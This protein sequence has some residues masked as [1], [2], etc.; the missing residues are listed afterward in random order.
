[1]GGCF[2][3]VVVSVVIRCDNCGNT[4]EIEGTPPERVVCPKCGSVVFDRFGQTRDMAASAVAFKEKVPKRLGEYEIISEIRRGAMG[5]VYR[6]YQRR[7][8]RVVA[9]K[10]LIAGQHA[11]EEQVERFRREASSIARLSHPA[12]VPLYD[13]G[14]AEGFHYIAMEYV[15]GESLDVLLRRRGR[16]EVQDAL[17]IIRQVASAL[18]HAHSRGIVHRDIKPANILLDR[19]G[20]VRVTDFGLAK[21]L[22]AAAS[23]TQSGV[24][25]GTPHYMSPEQARGRSKDVDIR[26]DVYSVGA[27]LYEM[28]VGRPPFSGDT[29]VDIILKVIDE[30]P[31]PP[32]KINPSIPRDLETI[33]L[34]CLSKSPRQR[35]PSMTAFLADIERFESGEGIEARRLGILRRAVRAIRRRREIAAAVFAAVTVALLFALLRPASPPPPRPEISR[36]RREIET[37]KKQQS[38][39]Q[40]VWKAAFTAETLKDWKVVG[41]DISYADGTVLL[42]AKGDLFVW[43]KRSVSPNIKFSLQFRFDDER[44]GYFGVIFCALNGAADSGY[45]VRIYGDKVVLYKSGRMR[46]VRQMKV[47][48]FTVHSLA[49]K[50]DLD[51][52]EVSLDDVFVMEFADLRPIPD[53]RRAWFALSARDRTLRVA[54]VNLWREV[55]PSRADPVQVANQMVVAGRLEAA[56]EV[57]ISILES[58]RSE[59]QKEAAIYGLALAWLLDGKT[60]P[61]LR[62]FRTVMESA[63]LWGR[64]ARAHIAL[65]N[66]ERR[67]FDEAAEILDEEPSLVEVV[68]AEADPESLE[69]FLRHRMEEALAAGGEAKVGLIEQVLW[70]EGFAPDT[71][72][73][74]RRV[75]RLRFALAQEK[76]RIGAFAEAE[77]LY[78][79]VASAMDVEPLLAMEAALKVGMLQKER[80]DLAAAAKTL[81]LW[82]KQFNPREIGLLSVRQEA[83]RV[84]IRT[85]PAFLSYILRYPSAWLRCVLALVETLASRGKFAKAL[86]VLK[87]AYRDAREARRYGVGMGAVMPVADV[88][89]NLWRCVLL[90]LLGDGDGARDAARRAASAANALRRHAVFVNNIHKA[91][92]YSSTAYLMR[93]ADVATLLH[94]LLQQALH[95]QHQRRTVADIIKTHLLFGR[96]SDDVSQA[97]VANAP[98]DRFPA[99]VEQN[100]ALYCLLLAAL[101]QC[102]GDLVTTADILHSIPP[103]GEPVP[104]RFFRRLDALPLKTVISR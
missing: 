33:I 25:I 46:V 69:V 36:M 100:R 102:R 71:E 49:V 65:V 22:R 42:D 18:E 8:D 98:L 87:S 3:G 90:A 47:A 63:G 97:L 73:H 104:L 43:F 81:Q 94:L 32:R 85:S 21:E 59:A 27:V 62:R 38:R 41:R 44:D 77:V 57:Y 37:L 83:G 78:E 96:R 93:L 66:I 101:A 92:R 34:K 54:D 48:P 95:E 58:A 13:V 45:E 84:V 7:L 15:E 5:V 11:S 40:P 61:A 82:L 51:R 55:L 80:G 12:I 56:R 72:E 39:W 24:T 26:S 4:L 30:E 20:N 1:M 74:R 28:V 53:G 91:L 60:E 14:V 29:A 2:G 6:A 17:R 50:R 79:R 76:E 35:Y 52:I 68:F 75:A 31:T 9:L 88:V 89:F 10:V 64:L 86:S 99:F 70:Q 19:Q 23:F 16:L 103:D 67:R